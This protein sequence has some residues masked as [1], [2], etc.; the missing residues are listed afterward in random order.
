[1]SQ[2]LPPT[3]ASLASTADGAP[4]GARWR[5]VGTSVRGA[6]HRRR[7]L[8]NQ[9][10]LR[11]WPATGE[12]PPLAVAAADGHGSARCFRSDVGA[13][14]AVE[15]ALDAAAQTLCASPH[16]APDPAALEGAVEDLSRR[17]QAATREHLQAH[18][19]GVEELQRLAHEGGPAAQSA[20][21]AHPLLAYGATLTTV[22]LGESYLLYLQLGDGDILDVSPQGA[23]SRPL[24]GDERL[25][26]GQTT[27]LC[28]PQAW[29]DFRIAFR[30]LSPSSDPALVLLS[31]DGY[32]NAFR[33]DAGFLRVG[34]DLLDL[35]RQE[36][37]RAVATGLDSWLA[38][39]TEQGSGDDVTVG[40]LC[41]LEACQS[42]LSAPPPLPPPA[43]A[44]SEGVVQEMTV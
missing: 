38:E 27:S 32:A 31:T 13:R 18:P 12:G 29:R 44:G 40:L 23:V 19:F 15:I 22:W 7:G 16:A 21:E 36:G 37:L 8:P 6:A 4:G 28:A 30:T 26:G 17:W 33:E 43:E 35:V 34:T 42:P 9:D 3:P 25:F 24:P 1:V 10:A 20:L 5:V 2:D 11:W 39:A 41:R 14:L